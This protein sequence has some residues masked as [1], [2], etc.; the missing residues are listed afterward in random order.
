MTTVIRD[1]ADSGL[2]IQSAMVDH[3]KRF[4][5]KSRR[6][7]HII[8]NG[9]KIK[10][11]DSVVV[12][13]DGFVRAEFLSS[14]TETE[15]GFDIKLNGWLRLATD[16]K[17]SLLRTWNDP[18]YESVVEYPYH[19]SDGRL[20]VWN[21]YKARYPGGQTVEEKWTE[22]AGMWVEELSSAERI[23]HCSHGMISAPDFDS[24]IFK[25]TVVQ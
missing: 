21:V 9:R 8:W 10:T 11:A 2:T 20:W 13:P 15:Q 24:L 18:R 23:Y 14:K 16:E 4:P 17:V 19:S 1:Y 7:D 3:F 6:P 22:N 25:I 12:P 5:D